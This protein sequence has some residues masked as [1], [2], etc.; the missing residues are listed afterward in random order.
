[1]Y[2][3]LGPAY[4]RTRRAEPAIVRRLFDLLDI[5]PEHTCVDVACGTGNYTIALSA[6]QIRISGVDAEPA[7]I[8]QARSK[9]P[10]IDWHVSH[11]RI[12]PSWCAPGRPVPTEIPAQDPSP[13]PILRERPRGSGRL[14]P[15][16]GNGRWFA[17]AT[18]ADA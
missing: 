10:T 18:R 11:G 8:A 1:M 17:P 13:L 2:A 9:A 3:D 15:L 6:L 5:A 7:M 12:G 4:D 14:A 16:Q